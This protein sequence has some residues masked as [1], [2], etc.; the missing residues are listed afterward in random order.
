MQ[1]LIGELKKE[2]R[3]CKFLSAGVSAHRAN[4]DNFS[5]FPPE[6]IY[7]I[8]WSA[9]RIKRDRKTSSFLLLRSVIAYI[10]SLLSLFCISRHRVND[11]KIVTCSNFLERKKNVKRRGGVNSVRRGTFTILHAPISRRGSEAKG[12][13][14]LDM[15]LSDS[16]RTSSFK[17]S[18]WY[19]GSLLI[20]EARRS[21]EVPPSF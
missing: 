15:T 21:R 2:S 14:S 8:S 20:P 18:R 13:F 17:M 4:C 10:M 9:S 5:G 12:D 3:K 6:E 1:R 16:L 19:T 11:A 7:D